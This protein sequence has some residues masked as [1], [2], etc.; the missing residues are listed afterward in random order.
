MVCISKVMTLPPQFTIT[1]PIHKCEILTL[2]SDFPYIVQ[3]FAQAKKLS[4]L[5]LLKFTGLWH[6]QFN[7]PNE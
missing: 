2:Q 6:K 3:K 5:P 4:I 7:I 1:R